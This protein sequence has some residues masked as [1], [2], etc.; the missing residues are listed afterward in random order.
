MKNSLNHGEGMWLWIAR[1]YMGGDVDKM[2]AEF[3]RLK[4]TY[5][6]IKIADWAVRYNTDLAHVL[7][8]K[9][10]ENNI[11]PWGFQYIYGINPAQEAEVGAKF[12]NELGLYGFV[13]NAEKEFVNNAAKKEAAKI[14]MAKLKQIL[15]PEMLVGLSSYRYPYKY[16]LDYP[17]KEFLSKCDFYAPQVYWMGSHNAG[18]QL[19]DS[20]Q[21][22]HRMFSYFS[23]P[24][25]PLRP[26]GACFAEHGWAP[27]V[28]DVQQFIDTAKSMG[29]P[30]IDWWEAHN[31]Q[32]RVNDCYEYIASHSYSPA[33]EKTPA[34][35]PS[36]FY[37]GVVTA[38]YAL[39][40][41]TDPFVA[42]NNVS[43]YLRRG[44]KVTV[45]A[46]DNGWA[47]IHKDLPRWASLKYIQKTDGFIGDQPNALYNAKVTARW[48]LN[49]R[50]QPWIANN[51]MTT[52]VSGETVSVYKEQSGWAKISPSENKW[53]S[54]YYLRKI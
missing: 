2:I 35:Q 17:W 27:V 11:E 20:T 31:G 1:N 28:S 8:K 42:R 44:D 32:S 24:R 39:T 23:L 54:S 34:P 10:K 29:F 3:K 12:A 33:Q 52:L 6:I 16:F 14:Y 48:G 19:K 18:A 9:L 7:V 41:R 51:I 13:V 49:I 36:T 25:L 26:T 21:D 45:F 46:E 53:V 22:V 4:L 37:L 43:H 40:V 30:A 50:S 15:H 38:D 5:V 47:K